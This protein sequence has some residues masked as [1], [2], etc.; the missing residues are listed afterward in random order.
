MKDRLL[1]L[2]SPLLLLLFWEGLVRSGALDARFFPAPSEILVRTAELLRDGTLV[3]ATA[4]TLRRM[5]VG[6]LLAAVPAVLLGVAMGVSRTVRLL[7]APLVAS[8]YP[9]PKIALVPMVVIL[10]GLGEASKYAVVVISVFFLVA[11]NT[12]AGVLNVDERYFDIARNNGAR[13]WDLVWTVALPGALPSILTGVNLGLGFALTV[14][15]GTEL[16]L[17]Q[18]G[19]GALIWQSYQ[20]YDIP[21]IFAGLIVVALLG[22]GFNLAM[23]EVEQQLIPWRVAEGRT[24]RP[25]SPEQEP[26][27]RRFAR[28]WWLAVRPFSFTASV[29]PVTLG[30]VLA[31]YDGAWSWWYFLVALAGAVAIHAG[32][33]LIND[34]Y[35]WKKG[36]DTPESLGPNRALQEGML[37]SRQVFW[38]GVFFF[39][40]GS[41]LGLYLVATRGLLI[42]WLGI[43]SVLAGWFY[44]AGPKAFAYVGLGEVVV[45]IFMGPV[46]VVGSYYVLAQQAPLHVILLALPIGLL[47]AAI[48]HVN[49]MRDLEDDLARGK[50]TLANILGR[51]ASRRE[52][53][54][55]VGGG[56]GLLV[57]L[58]LAGFAPWFALLPLVTLPEAI[59]LIRYAFTTEAPQALNKVL[60]GTA[61]LHERFG[62]LLIAGIVAAMVV[63][64]A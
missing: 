17:P 60:R 48:L 54:L 35:D 15:V 32:T 7:L 64:L 13:G 8:L 6:F 12:V 51:R 16:L 46:M 5:A 24:R 28:I 53:L 59:T 21:T 11:I 49:N 27:V 4:T 30:A 43:F 38:G 63:R 39:A 26:R 44:T 10:L 52:Y 23:L 55:L 45:F 9:V 2:V 61:R 29:T 42:L 31:G 36:T 20:L 1:Q 19:L 56:Y 40:V 33:N 47:V 57:L 58:V 37:T 14:I 41:A 25:H 50:R 18:G 3:A 34:Y 62:W 22:W